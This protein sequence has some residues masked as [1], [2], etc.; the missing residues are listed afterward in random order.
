VFTIRNHRDE[1]KLF[2]G[3]QNISLQIYYANTKTAIIK[4]KQINR[5][6]YFVEIVLNRVEIHKT[7]VNFFQTHSLAYII[8]VSIT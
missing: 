8:S 5:T 6:L 4:G 1:E 3:I 2:I 7:V